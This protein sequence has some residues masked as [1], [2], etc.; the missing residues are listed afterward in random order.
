M[1]GTM[2]RLVR[3]QSP[4]LNGIRSSFGRLA[5]DPATRQLDAKLIAGRNACYAICEQEKIC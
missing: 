2:V 5:V 4:T 1:I 3:F